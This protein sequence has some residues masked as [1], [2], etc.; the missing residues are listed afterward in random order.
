MLLLLWLSLPLML[1]LLL[2]E[3]GED[4]GEETSVSPSLPSLIAMAVNISPGGRGALCSC[5]CCLLNA[6]CAARTRCLSAIKR[7][8][9]H[10]QSL[11]RQNPLCPLRIESKPWFLHLA[12][13]GVRF[14]SKLLFPWVK[15][16]LR[17]NW[18][19]WK[20][21]FDCLRYSHGLRCFF[22]KRAFC[23]GLLLSRCKLSND[24]VTWNLER[25]YYIRDLLACS[26]Q[27]K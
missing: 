27:T 5:I 3:F 26:T 20:L 9:G 2:L 8:F 16:I 18:E 23:S 17:V 21:L 6:T 7:H 4:G 22:F 14:F 15:L 10:R 11:H 19:N 13:F 12:H 1:L 25:Y 24:Y